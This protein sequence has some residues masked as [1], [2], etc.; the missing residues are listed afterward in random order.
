M[1]TI[2]SILLGIVIIAIVANL[3]VGFVKLAVTGKVIS[4]IVAIG[5]IILLV[6]MIRAAL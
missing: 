5:L 2:L 3:F 6:N 1:Y 4:S